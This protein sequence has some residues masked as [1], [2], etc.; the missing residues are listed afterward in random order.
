VQ[1]RP[2]HDLLH[3]DH[4]R[5]AALLDAACRPESI[6]DVP[7]REFRAGL[8]R[9]IAMEEKI[10]LPAVKR[11]NGGRSLPIAKQMRLDHSA[12][13]ALLVPTP[14]PMIV[15]RLR[16]LLDA[17]NE[18]EEGVEGVYAQCEA[19]ARDCHA[20]VLQDLRSARSVKVA[21]YQDVPRAFASIERLLRATGRFE[22]R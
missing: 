9:H 16:T 18:M 21:P 7:F 3:D 2:I 20:A 15:V 4:R 11:L 17:H 22:P 13:A 5:L 6:D 19:I 1:A 10:L 12:L 14:T 8:L